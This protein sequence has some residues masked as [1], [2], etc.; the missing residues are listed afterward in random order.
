MYVLT[1]CVVF[2]VLG[3]LRYMRVYFY[4]EE[5][6]SRVYILTVFH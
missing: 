2:Q 4:R 6:G 3:V 1:L 5:D